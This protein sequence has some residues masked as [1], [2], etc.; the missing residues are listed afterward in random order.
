[1]YDQDVLNFILCKEVCLSAQHV[2]SDTNF[3]LIL[4]I[5]G[6]QFLYYEISN[7]R[8]RK[9]NHLHKATPFTMMMPIR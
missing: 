2:P 7:P 4:P 3:S 9:A 6:T 1:M 8:N 5:Y